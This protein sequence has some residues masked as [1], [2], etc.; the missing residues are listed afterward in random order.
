MLDLYQIDH[1]TQLRKF[2]PAHSM[3]SWHLLTREAA[4][5]F[6]V[7]EEKY[8]HPFDAAWGCTLCPINFRN[9]VKRRE[10]IAHVKNTYVFSPYA[11]HI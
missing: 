5:I 2:D 8:P 3:N 6:R 9:Y 7:Y 4:R 10:A 1:A 11:F